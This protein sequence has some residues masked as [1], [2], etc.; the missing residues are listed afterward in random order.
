MTQW[1]KKAHNV[2]RPRGDLIPGDYIQLHIK[3]YVLHFPLL[4]GAALF[5]DFTQCR[6]STVDRHG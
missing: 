6:E 2:H 3:Y 4:L 1:V 5:V